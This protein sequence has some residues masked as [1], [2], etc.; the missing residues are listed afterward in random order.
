MTPHRRTQL[1]HRIGVYQP[2][3]EP[4]EGRGTIRAVLGGA[5]GTCLLFGLLFAG[6]WLTP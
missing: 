2:L 5:L 1:A 4:P 3:T 6:L